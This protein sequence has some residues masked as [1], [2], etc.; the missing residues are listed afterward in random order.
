MTKTE[1]ID[2][3]H[4]RILRMEGSYW[5]D[6]W[7]TKDVHVSCESIEDIEGLALTV[8]N[9]DSSIRYAGNTVTVVC[10]EQKW[11][12][13]ELVMAERADLHI[14]ISLSKGNHFTISITS[15]AAMQP[16]AMDSRERGVVLVSLAAL[17]VAPGAIS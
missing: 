1:M 5:A 11:T 14:P 6:G 15:T 2:I 7:I 12:T 17:I 16:D 10:N 8:W 3:P 4:V 9:P 13:E